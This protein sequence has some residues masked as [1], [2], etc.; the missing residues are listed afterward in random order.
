M[1]GIPTRKCVGQD[2]CLRLLALGLSLCDWAVGCKHAGG[3]SSLLQDRKLGVWEVKTASNHGF[4]ILPRLGAHGK[5]T[6]VNGKREIGERRTRCFYFW[7]RPLA[8]WLLVLGYGRLRSFLRLALFLH[9]SP[10][11]F[12]IP[13]LFTTVRQEGNAHPYG[14]S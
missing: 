14:R 9:C 13:F 7:M 4:N 2:V 5:S 6:E 10:C 1:V 12:R 11:C 3:K 8:T